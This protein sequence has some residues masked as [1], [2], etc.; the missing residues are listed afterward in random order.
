MSIFE[1]QNLMYYYVDYVVANIFLA[2]FEVFEL[3]VILILKLVILC[4]L[5]VIAS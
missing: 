3:K 1:M 4:G 2:W 5:H